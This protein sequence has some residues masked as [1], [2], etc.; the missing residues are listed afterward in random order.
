MIA[1]K[2]RENAVKNQTTLDRTS[3]REI[4]ITRT[5]NAPARIVFEAWTKPEFVRRW[6]APKSRGVEIVS[7]DAE[8]RVGGK[9]RYVLRH[10]QHGEFAFW[11]TYREITPNSRL[12][13][14]EIFE[15]AGQQLSDEQG[16]LVTVTFNEIEGRT[17]MVSRSL[18]PS[19]EILDGVLATGME[20]GMRETMDQLDELVQAL[21]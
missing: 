20:D 19:K 18:F 7:C 16:A 5:F 17:K 4:V 21:P 15:P 11:G 13:H 2:V 1:S 9:Y 6:W 14:T 12:V 3:D 8:L 10:E